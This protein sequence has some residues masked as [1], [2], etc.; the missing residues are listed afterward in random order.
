MDNKGESYIFPLV[1]KCMFCLPKYNLSLCSM[2]F[3]YHYISKKNNINKLLQLGIVKSWRFSISKF[4]MFA[5]ISVYP[6]ISYLVRSLNSVLFI[7]T[8]LVLANVN[9][10]KGKQSEG[11]LGNYIVDLVLLSPSPSLLDGVPSRNL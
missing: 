10:S 1:V 9:L 6:L 3:W 4:V 8:D 5:T 7:V 2:S 11:F